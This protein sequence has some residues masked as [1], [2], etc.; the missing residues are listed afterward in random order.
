MLSICSKMMSLKTG[1]I[2]LCLASISSGYEYCYEYDGFQTKSLT[3]V[4]SCCGTSSYRYCCGSSSSSSSVG[5]II[6]IVVGVALLIALVVGI[7][8]CCV[9]CCK[10]SPGHRGQVVTSGQQLT[11]ISAGPNSVSGAYN[12]GYV[13]TIQ[14]PPGTFIQPPVAMAQPPPPYSPPIGPGHP[15]N[16]GQAI[17][18]DQ[19]QHI[20][21]C[22]DKPIHQCNHQHIHQDQTSPQD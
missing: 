20:H 15:Q 8:V 4:Y 1:W 17:H 7:I 10:S 6:G 2:L 12:A 16:Q 14:S 21:Q 3:C 22:R 9:C 5:V 19:D 13:H 18:Q 11:V